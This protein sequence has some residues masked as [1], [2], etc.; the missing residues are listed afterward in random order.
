MSSIARHSDTLEFK[1]NDSLAFHTQQKE[2]A[3]PTLSS[4]QVNIA[5]RKT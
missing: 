4:E 5:T 3:K 2:V 1:H